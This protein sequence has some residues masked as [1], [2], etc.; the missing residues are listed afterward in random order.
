M[1]ELNKFKIY[2]GIIV[3]ILFITITTLFI[4]YLK[5]NYIDNKNNNEEEVKVVDTLVEEVKNINNV[6]FIKKI[7]EYSLYCDKTKDDYSLCFI[8][9]DNKKY[10]TTLILENKNGYI[11]EFEIDKKYIF[12]S[13]E[14][15][16]SDDYIIDEL[17]KKYDKNRK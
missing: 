2:I 4:L 3:G 12:N 11:L 8:K 17:I 5:K 13:F 15:N 7:G 16:V 14:D 10:N 6:S 1:K 9:Y